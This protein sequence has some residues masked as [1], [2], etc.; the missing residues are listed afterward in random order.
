MSDGTL[1]IDLNSP[2]DTR[3]L[4]R[5]LGE[6]LQAGDFI[7][8]YGPLGAGKT[9]FVQGLAQGLGVTDPVTSPTFIIMRVYRSAPVLCHVDA[10]RLCRGADL[11]DIG[12]AD[13]LDQAVIAVEWAE[14]VEG[15]LPAER[16]EV[17]LEHTE[18]GRR[19][20]FLARG[21]RAQ[22]LLERLR[23]ADI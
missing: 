12:L 2:D 16:L 5:M 15:A 19:A 1:A 9:C 20:A 3:R 18:G 23:H 17:H 6:A 11:E 10:Y 21:V 7:A 22:T 8:L 14:N 13:W 4:A